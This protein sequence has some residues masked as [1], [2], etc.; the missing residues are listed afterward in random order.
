MSRWTGYTVT[1]GAARRVDGATLVIEA[2]SS[3]LGG[4]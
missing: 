3:A 4:V 2:N 1:S